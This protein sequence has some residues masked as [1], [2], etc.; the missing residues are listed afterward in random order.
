MSGDAR[1][2]ERAREWLRDGHQEA[3][4]PTHRDEFTENLAK[5]IKRVRAE[6]RAA[7]FEKAAELVRTAYYDHPGWTPNQLAAAI[8]ALRE[9]AAGTKGADRK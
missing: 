9:R 5:F 4:K 3:V 8:E 6:E 7:T 1:D 2:L